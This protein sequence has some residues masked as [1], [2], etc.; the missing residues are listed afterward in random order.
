VYGD[1][2]LEGGAVELDFEFDRETARTDPLGLSL[3]ALSVNATHA[4]V[5]L[6]VS[7]PSSARRGLIPG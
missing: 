5:M 3:V 2:N 4:T 7:A 1:H 6:E